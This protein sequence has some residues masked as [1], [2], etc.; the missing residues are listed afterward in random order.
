VAL[1]ESSE[2]R[3]VSLDSKARSGMAETATDLSLLRKPGFDPKP[4][5]IIYIL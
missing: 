4:V 1:V 3:Q 2:S 5:C